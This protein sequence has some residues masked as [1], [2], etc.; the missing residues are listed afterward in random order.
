VQYSDYGSQY[1]CLVSN[2]YGVALSA[3]A[4]LTVTPPSVVL[5]GGFETGGFDDWTTGGNFMDCA[6]TTMAPFVHSGQYGAELGP[7]GSPGQLS[8]TLTTTVGQ[9][10][11]VSCWLYGAGQ[12]PN[13]FS[14]AWDGAF[15]FNQQNLGDLLWTNLQFQITATVTNTVLTFGFR[16]DLS[17]FGLDDIAV[18]PLT[19][20]PPQI[21]SVTLTNGALTFS[22]GAQSN[23]LYQVQYTTNLAQGGWI[24]LGPPLAAT[25]SILT[26]TDTNTGAGAQ[27]YRLLLPP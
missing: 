12:I 23:Q 26:V 27:F 25:N 13:S 15:L 19:P 20:P 11:L 3:N 1:S 16:N 5:N 22:W 17:Y 9:N 4:L 2:A 21:Q 8:Q 7:V 6:I 24:N 14:V 18:C 10:Y